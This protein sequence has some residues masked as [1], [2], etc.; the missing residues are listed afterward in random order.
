MAARC[1]LKL[2]N[3]L[4]QKITRV[5]VLLNESNQSPIQ[6]VYLLIKKIQVR[7]VRMRQWVSLRNATVDIVIEEIRYRVKVRTFP[8]IK[9]GL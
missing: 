9:L 6:V 8:P 4:F 1:P 7:A 3:D 5:I 2:L